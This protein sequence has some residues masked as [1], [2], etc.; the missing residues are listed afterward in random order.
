M[1]HSNHTPMWHFYLICAISFHSTSTCRRSCDGRREFSFC[2]LLLLLKNAASLQHLSTPNFLI[3]R[4][5]LFIFT[6]PWLY[7]RPHAIPSIH[8]RFNLVCRCCR[9]HCWR[10]LFVIFLTLF[11]LN[12]VCASRCTRTVSNVHIPTDQSDVNYLSSHW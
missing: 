3:I 4:S 11:R 10:L 2:L 6:F 7:V 1:Q 5:P 9:G 8:I 12:W